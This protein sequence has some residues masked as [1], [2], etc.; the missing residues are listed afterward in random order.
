MGLS[1][2]LDVDSLLLLPRVR[3]LSFMNNRFEG[4]IPNFKKLGY[5]K[6]LYLSNNQFS[7]QI[8]DD[9]FVGMG[10]LKKLYLS[11]NRFSGPL[12]SS[13][14][15]LPKLRALHLEGNQFVG[16]IPDFQQEHLVVV[17]LSD[18]QLE[19][20]IPP[21][22]V[23]QN[24]TSLQGN[25]DL[26]GKPLESVCKDIPSPPISPTNSTNLPISPNAAIGDNNYESENNKKTSG[27]P[28]KIII[29]VACCGVALAVIIVVL[30]ICRRSSTT[31]ELGREGPSPH[32]TNKPN[33]ATASAAAA[34]GVVAATSVAASNVSKHR[35]Q[36]QLAAGGKKGGGHP[37]NGKL[38]FVRDDRQRFDLQD[39]L[40]A[41]AEVLGSGHFGSSYKAVFMDGQA[42][43]V[44]RFKQM[45]NGGREEFHEHMRRLGRLSHSNLLPLVAYYYRKEEK[46]LVYDYVQ[47]GS[48]ASHLH[49]NQQGLDWA[50]RLKIVK[51][52]AKGLAY[53]HNELPS[54]IVPHGHLKSSNVLLN[55]SFEPLL[56]DYTLIPVVNPELAKQTL[57][58]YKSPE[59]AKHNRNTKKTDVWSLGILILEIL[60]GKF[61]ANYLTQGTAN[62][63]DLKSWV[64]SI[65]NSRH[66]TA[67][68]FDKEMSYTINDKEEMVKLLEIGIAC[69]EED[70]E[71]RW[72]LKEAVGNIEAIGS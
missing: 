10:S 7:G 9:A 13:L 55:E 23:N 1:G 5:L 58:A 4:P 67:K 40:R 19:G 56:M 65:A 36:G 21:G 33:G 25:K 37:D 3:Y 47:N 16:R 71:K 48:L 32:D 27:D 18:N 22:L 34:T 69:C 53:L 6:S 72:D 61:P 14:T 46:L 44:K 64:N 17:N 57:V 39:L 52:V 24:P 63:A 8:P 38:S 50:T 45:N 28:L 31:P 29:I 49:G 15:L 70:T 43:V 51:G 54:L 12:P 35:E 2:N 60:T 20:P 68:V 66:D 26:C 42:V 59:Y 62:V 41:S 11:H 30:L